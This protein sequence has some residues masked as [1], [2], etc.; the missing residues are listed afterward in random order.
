MV[1]SWPFKPVVEGSSPS[2]LTTK[3]MNYGKYLLYN[4]LF[5]RKKDK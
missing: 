5:Q 4:V 2:R 1:E 3:R